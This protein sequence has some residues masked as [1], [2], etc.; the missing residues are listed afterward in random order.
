M[1][2]GNPKDSSHLRGTDRERRAERQREAIER[3]EDRAGRT[4]QEQLAILGH[5]PGNS[6]KERAKLSKLVENGAAH[7]K[8]GKKAA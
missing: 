6:A 2:Q 7:K 4:T 1:S 3:N 5:R 8:T